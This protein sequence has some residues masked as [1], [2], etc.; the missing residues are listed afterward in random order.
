MVVLVYLLHNLG[1][2]ERGVCG[3]CVRGE[4]GGGMLIFI[5]LYDII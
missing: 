1:E 4:L 3:F 5:I 2:G